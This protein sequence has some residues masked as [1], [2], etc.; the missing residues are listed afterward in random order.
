MVG[1]ALRRRQG[2][3]VQ[4][5]PSP[6]AAAPSLAALPTV[7]EA[8]VSGVGVTNGEAM[9]AP[10]GTPT[11]VV[12]R[13][14]AAIQAAMSRPETMKRLLA[15]GSEAATGSPDQLRAHLHA[16]HERWTRVIRAAGIR[17]E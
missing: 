12:D 9:L 14:N 13:L 11:A 4:S 5:P 17:G 15:D 6:G 7:A 16:E 1:R 3:P 10:K 8:G 2:C